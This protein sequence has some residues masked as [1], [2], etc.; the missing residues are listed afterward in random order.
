MTLFDWLSTPA[1]LELSHAVTLV[2]L[3]VAAWIS[4]RTHQT[5]TA[6]TQK[7]D[8]HIAEH[9]ADIAHTTD[10]GDAAAEHN[11]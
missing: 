4:W 6:N 5:A 10:S 11:I 3:A 8:N 1:G 9:S 2:L 7:L